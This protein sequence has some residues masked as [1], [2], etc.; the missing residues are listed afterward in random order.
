MLLY[1]LLCEIQR[2]SN[3]FVMHYSAAPR[4]PPHLALVLFKLKAIGLKSSRIG[5]LDCQAEHLAGTSV[6]PSRDKRRGRRERERSVKEQRKTPGMTECCRVNR[7][8]ISRC[9]QLDFYLRE[10]H[11]PLTSPQS[12]TV[13]PR[14]TERMENQKTETNQNI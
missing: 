9:L 5:L 11:S 3:S 2:I 10:T 8:Q 12:F 4:L 14:D 6:E 1:F 7:H 13:R